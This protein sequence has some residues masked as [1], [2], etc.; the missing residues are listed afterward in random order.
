ML[1]TQNA[2]GDVGCLS[3]T[4]SSP[5]RTT[6]LNDRTTPITRVVGVRSYDTGAASPFDISF[7]YTSLAYVYE[8]IAGACVDVSGGSAIAGV[9]SDDSVSTVQALPIAFDF[10]GAPV[11]GFTVTS[12]GFMQLMPAVS[13]TGS[14]S[15][16]NATVPSS[17]GPNGFIAPFWDDLEPASGGA[18]A[19]FLVDGAMGSRRMVVEWTNWQAYDDASGALTFQ[20]HLFEGTN[21]IEP[22]LLDERDHGHA[23]QRWQRDRRR[24]ERRRNAGLQISYDTAGAVMTGS[25]FRITTP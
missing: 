2:C 9:T 17:G 19:T 4:D 12:N 25:G 14:T 16:G 21:A 20:A 8:P 11:L 1:F 23:S 3:S 24:R 13:G 5:E 6:I 22:L 15:T 18:G 7:T 10:F